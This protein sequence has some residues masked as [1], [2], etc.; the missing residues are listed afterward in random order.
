[1]AEYLVQGESITAV[2]DA[3]R[4]K[5]G[6][7]APLSFPDGMANAVREI[8]S[9]GA[10]SSV[11]GKTGVVKLTAGD[12]GA[13]PVPETASV[14]QTIVVKAVDET[15]KPTEW[16][17]AE[18]P[19]DFKLI[20]SNVLTEAVTSIIINKDLNGNAFSLSQ[21]KVC[22]R[23]PPEFA[24]YGTPIY[25]YC[26]DKDALGFHISPGDVAVNDISASNIA[27][28]ETIS[29]HITEGSFFKYALL[30]TSKRRY[31]ESGVKST[32]INLYTYDAD[33]PFPVGT[34]IEVY[35]K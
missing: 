2:A 28:Y 13:V 18:L 21:W 10:V 23:I 4:E 7:T 1:M 12:V 29:A 6:T 30:T 16:E 35:G 9:G 15:G 27:I 25:M 3:I 22:L 32:A 34:F 8:Q 26:I 31:Y 17:A 19:N 11:N 14:G 5:G 33:K 20:H 24:D